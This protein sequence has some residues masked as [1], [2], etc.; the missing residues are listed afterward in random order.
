MTKVK[1]AIPKGM[2]DFGPAEMARRNYIIARLRQIFERFGYLPLETPAMEKLETLTGKYGEEGDKLIFKVLNSGDFLKKADLEA[3]E[4]GN[5]TRLTRSIAEKGLRYDLTIPFA[6]YVAMNQGRITFPFRRYQIQAVWRA[7]RPQKGR[8]REFVQCDVDVIGSAGLISEAELIQIYQMAFAS[9]NM[10][11]RIRV[12]NRKILEGLAAYLGVED[13]FSALA[14]A[15]DKL[16]KM[17]MAGIRPELAAR[18]LVPK[19]IEELERLIE[20]RSWSLDQLAELLDN[21]CGQEGIRELR[22]IFSFLPEADRNNVEFDLTLARGLDYYTGTIFEVTAEGV[23]IGSV[24]GGGR[25]DNLTGVFG[26]PGMSG[27]GISFGLDRIYDVME[28]LELFPKNIEVASQVLFINFGAEAEVKSFEMLSRFRL[29]GLR[30]EIYPDAVKIKKQMKYANARG[31]PFV[32]M[33]GEE[34]IQS[35][36]VQLKD[37]QSGSQDLMTEADALEKIQVSLKTR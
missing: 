27:V 36:M 4:T 18:G 9:L 33:L 34:E 11:I 1:A 28:E 12:N 3:L 8:Y 32:I 14:V 25:Y 7:D 35:A 10:G 20:K 26:L 30:C 24:G 31:I 5:L 2:R 22:K 15:L 23:E 13:Q 37:M 17:G 6:R 29:L 21:E 16:D 19:A